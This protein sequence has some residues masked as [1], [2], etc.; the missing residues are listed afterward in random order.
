MNRM[1]RRTALAV[2]LGAVSS[3]AFAADAGAFFINSYQGNGSYAGVDVGCKSTP[4]FGQGVA[5]DDYHSHAN[6]N[7]ANVGENI[8]V[9]S[10]MV[11]LRF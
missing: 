5:F 11:E 2:V 10:G 4:N 3:G 1:I 6:L 7:D 9:F 8:G